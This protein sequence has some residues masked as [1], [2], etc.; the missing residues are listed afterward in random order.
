MQPYPTPNSPL[1]LSTVGDVS[2]QPGYDWL[3]PSGLRHLI[4]NAE[5]RVSSDGTIIP[6]NGLAPAILRVGRR[7]LIDLDAFEAWLETHRCR[8]GS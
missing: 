5:D 2:K 3:T 6:G 1:R 7:V 8:R 4:F